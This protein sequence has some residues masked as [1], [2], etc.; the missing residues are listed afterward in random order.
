MVLALV[1]TVD[2]ADAELAS[3]DLWSLGVVA[4]EERLGPSHN[5]VELWT[6]LGEE[7]DSVITALVALERPW[8]WRFETVDE[9]VS[10]TWRDFATATWV[11]DD[12][13]VYPAWM[14]RPESAEATAISIDPGATF[15]M[16]DHPTTVLS[17]RALRALPTEAATV[18]D[19]GCGSGVLAIAAVLF[20]ATHAEAIDISPAAVP[21]T[22]DNATRN[23]VAH[24]IHVS[25]TPLADVD[26]SYDI[27]LANI[28]A[29]ALIDLSFD[30]KRVLS[31]TGALVISGILA[32]RHDHVLAALEPL[33]VVQR[34]ELENWTAITL[35]W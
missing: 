33:R 7:Q 25:T 21:T 5:T 32:E 6:S 9:S 26:G 12:L 1:V 16:G 29:P 17:L 11:T 15:G 23:N 14:Q 34:Y 13:V 3:D 18:L 28:L 19:V 22:I 27:V 20:G 10:E 24:R 8:T 35:R 4:V 30:L 31:P 2:T